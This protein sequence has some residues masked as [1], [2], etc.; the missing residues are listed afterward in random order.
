MTVYEARKA[1]REYCNTEGSKHYKGGGVEPL[2]L[3]I[4]KGLHDGFCIGNIIKYATRFQQTRNLDDLKK[5]SDYAH[6]LCGVEI[7]KRNASTTC[8]PATTQNPLAEYA[9]EMRESFCKK[10]ANPYFCEQCQI[11]R[12][13][14]IEQ[15]SCQQWV[16]FDPERAIGIMRKAVE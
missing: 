3:T 9:E 5:V 8:D 10:R 12:N 6:I 7:M 1:G 16:E 13:A 2:D 14:G 4:A 11:G 15:I